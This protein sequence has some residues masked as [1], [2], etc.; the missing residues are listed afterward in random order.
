MRRRGTPWRILALTGVAG[1]A[2]LVLWSM[3][4]GPGGP[5][6]DRASTPHPAGPGAIDIVALGTSLTLHA[7]WPEA[8]T[9]T[10]QGCAGRPVA[11]IRLALPGATSRW[12]R[13]VAA[14]VAARA[15]DLVTIEFAIND[16]DI[17]DGIGRAEAIA[18]LGAI[19]ATLRAADPG[20]RIV[21]LTTNPV[22]GL[23]RLSRPRLA[24]YHADY[25]GLAESLDLGLVDGRARWPGAGGETML[26]AIH[27]R[28]EAEAARM[29]A[30]VLAVAARA[31]ALDCPPGLPADP[32]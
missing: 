18:N 17:F 14:A 26:D 21:L 20:V 5:P 3:G 4:P 15:P 19:V 11:L 16:A 7:T 1:L 9:R 23:G 13:G 29:T 24:G 28:P 27:P 30:P 12:G 32:G 8:V 2:G 6:R 31:L 25:H 10:L 22:A